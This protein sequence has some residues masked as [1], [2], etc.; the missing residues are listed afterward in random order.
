MPRVGE[1]Q[2]APGRAGDS[3]EERVE[4]ADV[5]DDHHDPALPGMRRRPAIRNSASHGSVGRPRRTASN[6][7]ATSS[8]GPAG[9]QW[10]GSGQ[11]WKLCRSRRRPSRWGSG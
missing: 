2:R 1:V 11:A 8:R 6:H 10:T 9:A 5:V 3:H 7:A 4:V